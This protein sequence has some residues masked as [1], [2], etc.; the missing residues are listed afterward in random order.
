[1]DLKI[2]KQEK[3]LLFDRED[4]IFTL[5]NT[6]ATPSRLE[7]RDLLAAKTGKPAE[8][9]AV[10][11]INSEFGKNAATGTAH[12]YKSK[13]ELE[14]KEPKFIIKRLLPK[15]K[16]EK[17]A[18]EEL[19]A[20]SSELE[21]KNEEK[22]EEAPAEGETPKEEATEEKPSEDTTEQSSAEP[23][24]KTEAKEEEIEKDISQPEQPVKSE[25][26][27]E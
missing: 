20:E 19:T 3:N 25:E 18:P 17:K 5:S 6:G 26:K 8:T 16:K 15:Q 14:K 21:A 1:M 23:E 4:I 9:I 7:T 11:N 27:G 24:E 12:I 13:A 2:S 22:P 10:I